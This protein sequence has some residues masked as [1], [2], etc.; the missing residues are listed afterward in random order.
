MSDYD[1]EPEPQTPAAAAPAKGKT[2]TAKEEQ[3]RKRKEEIDK[4]ASKKAKTG[5]KPT[6]ESSTTAAFE[7]V[8][9]PIVP[10][11]PR[12]AMAA[13]IL[14]TLSDKPIKPKRVKMAT[15]RQIRK[16]SSLK[17]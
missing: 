4:P 2:K 7:L 6:A 9:D 1:S 11:T 5:K 10:L 16:S 8:A 14:Q 3:R 17:G 15:P 12:T 13:E